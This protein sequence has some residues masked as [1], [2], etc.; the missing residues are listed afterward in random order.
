MSL[1]TTVVVAVGRW[2]DLLSRTGFVRANT[3]V[4]HDAAYT[5]ITPTQ[6]ATA[7]EWLSTNS[8][9]REL[10]ELAQHSGLRRIPL[11]FSRHMTLESIIL[12]AR[13]PWLWL[14]SQLVATPDD[15]PADVAEWGRNLGMT[16][17]ECLESVLRVS[18]KLNLQAR[19]DFGAAGE[20]ALL[21]LLESAW[22]GS[23]THVSAI[24]DGFGYDISLQES[25]S[26]WHLEV[27][28]VV[29]GHRTRFFLTRHEF[30]VA[31]RD[32]AWRLVV[33]S[34][35]H[36]G[37]IRS[38]RVVENEVLWARSPRD[39][40]AEATWDTCRFDLG[41]EEM[42]VPFCRA[43]RTAPPARTSRVLGVCW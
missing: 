28:T 34:M 37:A 30:E 26:E 42:G 33:V 3:I 7:L 10:V 20:S 2:L 43:L 1:P 25:G 6:Y 38:V 36:D 19:A 14:A 23:A 29:V 22:P 31:R 13:P 16:D 15:L 32:A 39:V 17:E 4:H 12:E 24:S 11:D 41:P 8:G 18:G 27:K 35:D 40:S 21:A 5:D 9:I